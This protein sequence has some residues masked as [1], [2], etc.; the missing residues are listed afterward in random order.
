MPLG[1]V[2]SER[3]KIILPSNHEPSIQTTLKPVDGRRSSTIKLSYK[4]RDASIKEVLTAGLSHG[5]PFQVLQA[6]TLKCLLEP[7]V[8]LERYPEPKDW[9]RVRFSDECHF[10]WGPEGKIWVLRRPWERFCPDCMVEKQA[11]AEKNLQELHCWAA[12]G[13]DF[14]SPLV[15]YDVPSNN[16]GKLTMQAYRDQILEPVVGSW[17]RAGHSF[18]LEEDND[19]G[20]GGR[21]RC[22]NI[23]NR[24]KEENGLESYFNCPLSPDFVPIERAWQLPKQYKWKEP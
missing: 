3:H 1:I 20:H 14:K 9:Y 13:H 11:P 6:S 17:L 16:N 10:G 18:V 8:M 24:W 22:N 23:V 5:K 21:K 4:L 2:S 19:S 15:W 12:V 7:R